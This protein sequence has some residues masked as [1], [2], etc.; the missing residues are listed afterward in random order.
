MTVEVSGLSE[1]ETKRKRVCV[2]TVIGESA[3]VSLGEC[4]CVCVLKIESKVSFGLGVSVNS[5]HNKSNYFRFN[6]VVPSTS[7]VS[8]S[9]FHHPMY[10]QK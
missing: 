4:V 7:S 10:H 5:C 9:P 3:S 1:L 8:Y 6:R 2:C